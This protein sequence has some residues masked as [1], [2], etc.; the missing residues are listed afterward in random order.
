MWL[1][2]WQSYQSE[3]GEGVMASLPRA[4]VDLDDFTESKNI[5]IYSDTG[6]GKTM[7]IAQL[8]G[9]VLIISSENGT[10]VIKRWL[11]R[12]GKVAESKRFKMWL[13]RQWQ[14]LEDAYIWLRDNPGVFDW[15]VIDTATS[16]QMRAMRAAME[17]A[18][19]RSP[20]TRDIDLPDRGEHQKMQNA[21]KRM[22][23][24]FNELPVNCLWMAQAMYR[25]NRDGDE[26]VL[27]F[28]MGK[29]FEVSAW[30]CAQMHAFGYYRKTP[31]KRG[32]EVETGRQLMF[33]S[34]ADK[35]GEVEYWA[36]DRYGVLPKRAMMSVGDKQQVLL[37]DLFDMIDADAGAVKIA[38]QR[39]EEHDDDAGAFDD[40]GT[41]DPDDINSGQFADEAADDP[42]QAAPA[43]RKQAA[44]P[45]AKKVTSAAPQQATRHAA[46]RVTGFQP[47]DED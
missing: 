9:K 36:K 17:K 5:M 16:V 46:K 6:V 7:L 2:C 32:E 35:K 10:V 4:I 34:Y 25:V 18:V 47:R 20:E 37:G 28:I 13:V 21:M 11:K 39:V 19:A 29:D 23:T 27:P 14:D 40:G 1:R 15:V 38:Q 24:D 44:R 41:P 3:S 31:V 30:A 8:H 22:I 42:P 45:P 12:Y 33:E 43:P 26:I